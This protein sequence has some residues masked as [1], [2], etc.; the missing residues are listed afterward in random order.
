MASV[1]S[2]AAVMVSARIASAPPL[3]QG[4][5]LLGEGFVHFLFAHLTQ[6]LQE[7][8]GGSHGPDDVAVAAGSLASELGSQFVETVNLVAVAVFL[9]HETVAAEGVGQHHLRS[10]IGISGGHSPNDVGVV[11]V[12]RFGTSARLQAVHLE[13]GSGGP[14]RDE[15]LLLGQAAQQ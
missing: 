14:I 7:L 6:R 5:G 1:A 13:V 2:S 15:G 10:R 12:E 8:S 11:G 4:S 9:E 3:G